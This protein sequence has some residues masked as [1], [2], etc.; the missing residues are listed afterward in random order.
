[1]DVGAKVTKTL[2]GTTDAERVFTPRWMTVHNFLS[3]ALVA[4]GLIALPINSFLTVSGNCSYDVQHWRNYVLP[5]HI[6]RI[7]NNSILIET[8]HFSERAW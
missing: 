1:M 7:E 3:V 4:F 5:H 6:C 2:A 8:E